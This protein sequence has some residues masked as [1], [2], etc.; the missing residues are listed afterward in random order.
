MNYNYIKI[1]LHKLMYNI[2]FII[3]KKKKTFNLI[4]H[5]L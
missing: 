4:D 1:Q 2:I 5:I 3:E